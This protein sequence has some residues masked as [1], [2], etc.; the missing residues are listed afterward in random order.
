MRWTRWVSRS[1]SISPHFSSGRQHLGLGAAQHRLDARHQFRRRE[2]LDDIVVGA[3]GKPA[4]TLA[5]LAARRQHDDR[6]ALGLRALA[7]PAAELD[8]G[9]ARQHPVEDEKIGQAFLQADFRF[10]A[11]VDRIDV[12]A[13][14]LEIVA[15]EHA[16]RLLVFDN[17]NSWQHAVELLDVL[18]PRVS[19]R[20]AR[21]PS[22][23]SGQS[24]VGTYLLG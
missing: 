3:G 4:N 19:S 13:F 23:P 5:L 6:Q 7:Q 21:L 8:A 11:T 17:G 16:Q 9:D 22:R 10:V 20:L 12:E 1:S 18:D 15:E 2:R 24:N 14:G